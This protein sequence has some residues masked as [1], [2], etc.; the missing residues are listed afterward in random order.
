[1]NIDISNKVVVISGA[2]NGIGKVLAERFAQ[3]GT[4]LSLL[5]I[6]YAGLK[7]TANSISEKNF[8]TPL[9]IKCDVSS[10]DQVKIAIDKTIKEFGTVDVLLANAGILNASK[11]L[12]T[13]VKRWDEVF[14]VNVRGVFLC[15]R[16]VAPYLKEKR[17]GR[18][19]IASSFA[20][21]IP[22][23]GSAAYAASKSAVASLTRV[24]AA[25]LGP[26]NITVNSYAPGMIPSD[27]SGIDNLDDD[28]KN[29]MLDTLCIREWGSANDISSLA[30][31]LAS[32]QA[33]YI[34]GTLIDASGGKFSVQFSKY[35][36]L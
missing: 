14:D 19:I 13:S 18:I 11:I 31:F 1:M 30:I 20:A 8:H 16:A 35:A 23:V 36:R 9:I 12:E 22:S 34:T 15:A 32:D 21:I 5:D 4:K 6:D 3:E 27:M 29:E 7:D 10:E 33:K 17:S 2:A 25:E 28:R 26:W 24:L